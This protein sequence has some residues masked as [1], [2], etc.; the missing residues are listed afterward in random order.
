MRNSDVGNMLFLADQL[1]EDVQVDPIV[2]LHH[3]LVVGLGHKMAA[4]GKA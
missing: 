2:Q 1:V 3:R 4:L